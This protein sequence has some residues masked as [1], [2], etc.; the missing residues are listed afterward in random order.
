MTVKCGL[1]RANISVLL[2]VSLRLFPVS[3]L[4]FIFI[5][6]QG[7]LAWT[8]W[9]TILFP[10]YTAIC[11]IYTHTRARVHIALYGVSH[12]ALHTIQVFRTKR[13]KLYSCPAYGVP[14][15]KGVLRMACHTIRVLCI[16][17]ATLYRCC[18]YGMS[19]YTGVLHTV[20][21]TIQVLCIWLPHYTGV[22]H[23]ACH[24]IQVLYI[25]RATLYRCS[26]HSISNYA[27]VLH[28][29]CQIIKVLCIW[30]ATL[31]RCRIY[32]VPHYTGVLNMIYQIIQLFCVW[33]AK[34]LSLYSIIKRNL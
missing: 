11:D 6:Q 19:H 20:C 8:G 9:N 33:R 29:A 23:M 21:H 18:A 15:Y 27:A 4:L 24:T 3:I 16:W 5:F 28:M 2:K 26:A 17:G 12:K 31:Y 10:C 22:V 1:K 14:N 13:A 7:N 32:G 30:R 34:S 25:W